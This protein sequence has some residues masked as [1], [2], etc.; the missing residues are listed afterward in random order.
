MGKDSLSSSNVKEPAEEKDA[1]HTGLGVLF[2]LF[3]GFLPGFGAGIGMLSG[4]LI[5][6]LSGTTQSKLMGATIG[7]ISGATVGSGANILYNSIFS[8]KETHE[9]P[10]LQQDTEESRMSSQNM[11]S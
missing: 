3:S 11:P 9:T 8:R 2:P 4:L 1:V 10:S 6:M 7:S 5:G